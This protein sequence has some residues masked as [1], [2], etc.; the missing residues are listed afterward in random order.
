MKIKTWIEEMAGI[1]AP[2]GSEKQMRDYC[3]SQANGFEL[4]EDGCGNLLVHK[5]G[6]GKRIAIVCGMDERGIFISHQETDGR[7]RF[8]CLGTIKAEDLKNR[9]ILFS[10]GAIG[11]VECEKENVEKQWISL[12]V[13]KVKIGDC[14]IV[15]GGLTLENDKITGC[16]IAR[17]ACCSVLLDLLERD[18]DQA[19]VWFVFSALYQM[20][21]KGALAALCKIKPELA[22][23]VEPSSAAK[24]QDQ[25]KVT[26]GAGPV[27]KLRDGAFMDYLHLPERL[28][29]CTI[30]YQL[31]VGSEAEHNGRPPMI[32]GI[33][34]ILLAIPYE[35]QHY[36]TQTVCC[37]D[38]KKTVDLLLEL[39]GGFLYDL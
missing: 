14:G 27:V 32:F 23:L 11:V 25:S 26:L 1:Y 21:K 17:S 29:G 18:F 15:S 36:F 38:V 24:Q 37:D 2:S 39:T 34:S 30:P 3:R 35:E 4:S 5:P 16:G 7:L 22:F 19:D 31:Y 10:N 28:T 13:G 8:C 33:S 6:I 9:E 20:G 12:L